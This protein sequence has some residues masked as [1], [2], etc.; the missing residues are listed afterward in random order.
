MKTLFLAAI[1]T[2][3]LVGCN[4]PANEQLEK[5]KAETIAIHDEVMPRMEETMKARKNLRKQMQELQADTTLNQDSIANLY[6]EAI[7]HLDEADEAMMEW[8]RNYSALTSAQIE[9]DSALAV[10]EKEKERIKE[11]RLLMNESIDDAEKLLE[12]K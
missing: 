1:G 12:G 7:V 6:S 10:Y 2:A 3:L 4:N 5:L 8:M 11:V 9:T